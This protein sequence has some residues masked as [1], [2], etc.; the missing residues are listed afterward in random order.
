MRI[1]PK[2]LTVHGYYSFYIVAG[3][4]NSYYRDTTYY[5]LV[6][7]C[8][9]SGLS[10]TQSAS[11]VTSVSMKVGDPVTAAYTYYKPVSNRAYCPYDYT[12]AIQTGNSDNST[13]IV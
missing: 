7:G 2:D 9:H 8:S 1:L 6:V 13:K 5:T 10:A 12:R 3:R 4:P 11:F